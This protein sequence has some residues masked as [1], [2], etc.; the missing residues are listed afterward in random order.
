[1]F[2]WV[3]CLSELKKQIKNGMSSERVTCRAVRKSES[4]SST[5]EAATCERAIKI[6]AP[7]P[8]VMKRM[9]SGQR[10]ASISESVDIPKRNQSSKRGVKIE[11][12]DS[13][14]PKRTTRRAERMLAVAAS[15]K[16][17]ANDR[18]ITRKSKHSQSAIVQPVNKTEA[19]KMATRRNGRMPEKN[20]FNQ[21][22]LKSVVKI[23][24]QRNTSDFATASVRVS[25]KNQCSARMGMRIIRSPKRKIKLQ[26]IPDAPENKGPVVT[27]QIARTPTIK[28]ENTF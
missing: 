12:P 6:E 18:M 14:E 1:M 22:N 19:P 15:T 10:T 16:T 24:I 25:G 2:A 20:K 26:L 4:S 21:R 11:Q 13:I 28:N 5:N 9:T 8:L 3:D 23:R 7:E 27:I 17:A